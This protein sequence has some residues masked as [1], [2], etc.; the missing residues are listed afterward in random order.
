MMMKQHLVLT[1]LNEVKDLWALEKTFAMIQNNHKV[2]N[3]ALRDA[4]HRLYQDVLYCRN[5]VRFLGARGNVILFRPL[6]QILP[7]LR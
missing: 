7:S 3:G 6:R 2:A 5:I 1:S 4:A